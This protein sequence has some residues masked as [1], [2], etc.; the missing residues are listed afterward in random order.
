MYN[1]IK[2]P[3]ATGHVG[4]YSDSLWWTKWNTCFFILLV[5]CVCTRPLCLYPVFIIIFPLQ[6][7]KSILKQT[8]VYISKGHGHVNSTSGD[9]E[10]RGGRFDVLFVYATQPLGLHAA[11]VGERNTEMASFDFSAWA[12]SLLL[13]AEDYHWSEEK[14]KK[15]PHLLNYLLFALASHCLL[16][17]MLDNGISHKILLGI[18]WYRTWTWNH[19]S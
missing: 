4:S 1:K 11:G 5:Q 7:L 15:K 2:I 17:W 18:I 14:K 12:T 13:W 19:Y 16:S 8:V 3:N 9:E 6:P 10:G